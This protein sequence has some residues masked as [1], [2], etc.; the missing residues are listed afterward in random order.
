MTGVLFLVLPIRCVEA[1]HIGGKLDALLQAIGFCHLIEK[2][3]TP[4]LA[5]YVL[6]RDKYH[7]NVKKFSKSHNVSDS[8]S[9]LE[10]E[11]DNDN[12]NDNDNGSKKRKKTSEPLA[13]E[14]TSQPMKPMKKAKHMDMDSR[15]ASIASVAV[16]VA[17]GVSWKDMVQAAVAISGAKQ[18]V[19]DF[20]C[21]D[22]SLV[23]PKEFC[24]SMSSVLDGSSNSSSNS[25]V[26]A[27]RQRPPQRR[28][29]GG[30]GKGKGKKKMKSSEYL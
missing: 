21:R 7:V 18:N 2:K 30:N 27:Q 19:L 10:A 25:T 24:I 3:T 26:Q 11:S 6:K 16:P 5:F 14:Q 4:K 15:D 29:Q 28:P 12:D 23:S 22:V 1:H 13:G 9:L 20:F 17:V 8:L